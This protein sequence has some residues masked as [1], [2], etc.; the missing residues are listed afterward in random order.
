MGPS[1]GQNEPTHR[2]DDSQGL[3]GARA[4]RSLSLTH[5][6]GLE[7][8]TPWWSRVREEGRTPQANF[9]TFSKEKLTKRMV[10]GD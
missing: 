6:V 2:T 5:Q 3:Q 7:S 10:R 4:V 9:T 1:E 8:V